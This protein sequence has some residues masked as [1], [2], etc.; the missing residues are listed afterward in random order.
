MIYTIGAIIALA[1][2]GFFI[3]RGLLKKNKSLKFKLDFAE[4][5]LIDIEK[6][7]KSYKRLVV[8]LNHRKVESEMVKDSIDYV[9]GNDLAILVNS[10]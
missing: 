8:K 3:V 2:T 1:V 6:N 9:S 5:Q 7:V 10:L 4:K